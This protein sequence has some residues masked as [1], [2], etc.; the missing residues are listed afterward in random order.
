MNQYSLTK[1]R[2]FQWIIIILVLFGIAGAYFYYQS[3]ASVTM[4]QSAPTF[5]ADLQNSLILQ[6]GTGN[7]TFTRATTATFTDWEGLVKAVKSGETRFQGARRVEN[8][9]TT[10]EAIG[11]WTLSGTTVTSAVTDPLGTS[12]AFTVT[13]TTGSNYAVRL[14]ASGS[15]STGKSFRNSLWIKRRTGTGTIQ[16]YNGDDSSGAT[17]ITSL[18]TTSWQRIATPTVTYDGSGGG[19]IG[20]LIST[21]GDAVDI[22]HPQAEDVT[23]QSNQNPS[24]YVSCGVLSAPYHGAGVDC[25]KYFRTK[26]GNTVASNVVTEA[27][28]A[29]INSSASG[30]STLTTD[31]TGPYGYLAEGA[32]TNLALQSENL[33]TTWAGNRTSVSANSAVAPD[34]TTTADKLVEDST[35]SNTHYTAQSI[36][37]ADSTNYVWSVF[38]KAA[39]R[40]WVR[41]VGIAKTGGVRAVYVNLATGVAGQ[42]SGIGASDY[43]IEAHPNGWY[44][45]SVVFASGTGANGGGQVRLADSDGG[46]SYSGDGSSGVYVWGAQMEAASFVSSYIPTTTA[47]VTRNADVLSYAT[48][49]NFSDTAG[50]AAAEYQPL[51]WTNGNGR[52]IGR[53]SATRYVLASLATN[54]GVTSHDGTAIVSGTAA[55]PTGLVKGAVT[56]TGSTRAVYANG[57]YSGTGSYDGSWDLTALEIGTNSFHGTIRNIKI[58]ST[59]LSGNQVKNIPSTLSGGSSITAASAL[60]ANRADF[61]ANLTS[62]LELQRGKGVATFTRADG[63]NRRAAV[64]DFESVVRKVKAGEARFEGARRVENM[65]VQSENFAAAN[66]NDLSTNITRTSGQADPFGGTAAYRLA[67][68]GN[69]TLYHTYSGPAGGTGVQTIWMKSATGSSVTLNLYSNGTGISPNPQEVTITVTTAWQRF[70]FPVTYNTAANTVNFCIGNTSTAWG[71][72]EDIYVYGAQ[73]EFQNGQAN[74]NPSEYVSVGVKSSPYHGAGVDG[75]KYFDTQNGNTVA[76]NV[77]TEATGSAISSSTLKGY[78]AEGSRTNVALQSEAFGTTWTTSSGSITSNTT[79]AP[80]GTTTADTATSTGDSFIYQYF[81][82]ASATSYTFSFWA[83][84]ASGTNQMNIYF[85]RSSPLTY[86]ANASITLT[87]EWQRFTLTGTMLDTSQHFV[88]IGGAGTFSSGESIILW[89]GQIENAAFASSYIPT[90]TVS[91]T[92]AADTLTYPHTNNTNDSAGTIYAELTRITTDSTQAFTLSNGSNGTGNN[93]ANLWTS[94]TLNAQYGTGSGTVSLGTSAYSANTLYRQA[95]IY[96]SA[97]GEHYTG[98]SQIGSSVSAPSVVWNGVNVGNRNGGEHLYGT[99]K[100]VRI[101]KKALSDTELTGVTGGQE[102]AIQKTTINAPQND[103]QTSGLVGLWSFNGKDMSGTAAY[104]R[105]GQGNHGTLTNSPTLAI[106]KVGQAL[107]FDGTDD[108]IL[109][110]AN[111]GLRPS[112]VTVSAWVNLTTTTSARAIVSYT[113][114]AGASYLLDYNSPNSGYLQFCSYN[115]AWYCAQTLVSNVPANQWHHLVGTYDGTNLKLYVNGTLMD[116]VALASIDYT[117]PDSYV[118]IG[119]YYAGGVGG[120]YP[121]GKID[122]VRIYNDDLSVLDVANLYNLGR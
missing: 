3:R 47:S 38:V 11:S 21:A 26:N 117:A 49:G 67:P 62:T 92:R 57:A 83:K 65:L 69:A 33:S 116:T 12:T 45:V 28:G 78:L 9:A 121:S 54:S 108:H 14:Y 17:N 50:T 18:L 89:G 2:V 43:R 15:A 52:I 1:T 51:D 25:V 70:S 44:R 32:R 80:D 113:K 97:G 95:M 53:S 68:S 112:N 110:P 55:T 48:S 27:T 94:S 40:D 81:T 16:V 105:S 42:T 119:R 29:L 76:S 99:V 34:G 77:V 88:Q 111:S 120:H 66:W 87:T 85:G 103:K 71:S 4:K 72:G 114:S 93:R 74:T 37:L 118:T 22:W 115:A 36:A 46:E 73:V 23:G 106:G 7:P 82:P 31:A 6:Q 109:V 91:V 58:Y 30:A 39:G 100:N 90:T 35:A 63:A 104:D 19:Y 75:V 41:I 20:V 86:P 84:A 107:S 56:W 59:A 24:E 79:A 96:S 64:T 122:E 61:E 13:S 101:W 8:L 102:S 5:Q 98:G 10:S 60:K